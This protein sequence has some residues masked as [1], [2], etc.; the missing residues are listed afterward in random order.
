MKVH[1]NMAE[2]NHIVAFAVMIPLTVAY[3]F[4]HSLEFLPWLIALN[5]IGNIYPA[6]LQRM[7]RIRVIKV[8]ERRKKN[9]P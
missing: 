3:S 4:G 7:N 6:L 2:A 9:R 8:L 5:I 1:M